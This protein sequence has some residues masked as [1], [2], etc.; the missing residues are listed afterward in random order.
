VLDAEARKRGEQGG[1]GEHGC[2][3]GEADALG[4]SVCG[5]AYFQLIR[6]RSERVDQ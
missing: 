3:E 5:L 6:P 4:K 1:R 2:W